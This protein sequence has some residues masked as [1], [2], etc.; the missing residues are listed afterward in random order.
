MRISDWSSDVCSSDLDDEVRPL[1]QSF[2]G[3]AR[4][5]LPSQ[6]R[7]SLPVY[8]V[9]LEEYLA[10]RRS[11]DRAQCSTQVLGFELIT[12]A[13]LGLRGRGCARQRRADRDRGRKDLVPD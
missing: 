10:V 9:C 12:A 8:D 5:V 2:Y 4:R 11:P 7:R 13:L 1:D 6:G 3:L